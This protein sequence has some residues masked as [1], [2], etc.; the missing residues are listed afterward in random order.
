MELDSF[1]PYALTACTVSVLRFALTYEKKR[2][3][4]YDV[5]SLMLQY[6]VHVIAALFEVL[7]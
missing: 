2:L 6:P 1:F 4:V 7:Q 3:C 5:R